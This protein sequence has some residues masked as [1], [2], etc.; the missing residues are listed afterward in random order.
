MTTDEQTCN[1][2]DHVLTELSDHDEVLEFL[3]D[4]EQRI[5]HVHRT[6]SP[7]ERNTQL[8]VIKGLLNRAIRE[9]LER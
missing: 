8:V 3:R 6:S 9:R 4:L 1:D 2:I 7:L 5:Q